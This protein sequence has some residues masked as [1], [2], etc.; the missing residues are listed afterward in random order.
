MLKI[1][2]KERER[3]Y[4]NISLTL[5]PGR[6]SLCGITDVLCGREREHFIKPKTYLNLTL[7]EHFKSPGYFI[8]ILSSK[9]NLVRSRVRETITVQLLSFRVP[10][11]SF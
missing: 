5:F 8:K 2:R 3:E 9:A 6:D 1:K 4:L 10:C 7:Q 11:F